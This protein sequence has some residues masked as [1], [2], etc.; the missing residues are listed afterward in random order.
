MQNADTQ[1]LLDRFN[2]TIQKWIAFLDDYSEEMLLKKPANGSWSIGQVYVHLLEASRHFVRQM[3]AAVSSQENSDKESHPNI[4]AMLRNNAFP[5]ILIK[6]PASNAGT[7]QPN[8][9][10]EIRTGLVTIR[11]DVNRVYSAN[12]FSGSTGKSEHPGF[13]FL[14]ATEWLQV[15]EMHMRHHL[16]QKKRIDDELFPVLAA[17]P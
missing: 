4:Q 12:D 5:D 8:S 1:I 14:T 7:Q 6:G 2:D 3:K 13:R 16:R 10:E 17:Q 15:I 11:E 9:K